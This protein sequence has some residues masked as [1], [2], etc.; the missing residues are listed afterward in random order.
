MYKLIPFIMCKIILQLPE[1]AHE[2]GLRRKA[3]VSGVS[4]QEIEVH[5]AGLVPLSVPYDRALPKAFV[6]VVRICNRDIVPL[7]CR[8]P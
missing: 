2:H 6:L 7:T 4:V 3:A 8:V 1:H 5:T